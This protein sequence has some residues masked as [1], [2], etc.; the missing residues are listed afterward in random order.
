MTRWKIE[1]LDE[2][3]EQELA[4][5]PEDTRACFVHISELLQRYGFLNVGLPHVDRIRGNL[6]EM[7]MRSQ[8]GIA[9]AFYF[10]ARTRR[11]VVL[12][13]F[14]KRTM[15]RPALE[16]TRA[17]E[18]AGQITSE[19]STIR[20]KTVKD[21]HAEW[22]EKPGY[23]MAYAERKPEFKCA[24]AIIHA[25]TQARLTQSQL[26]ERMNTTRRTIARLEGGRVMPSRRM[27]KRIGAATGLLVQ[28]DIKAAKNNR[29]SLWDVPS[30]AQ[31][32]E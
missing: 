9:S 6:W 10:P 15:K 22:L 1:P 4:A 19:P 20:R 13:A 24:S 28:I 29:R 8:G 18:R 21:L 14:V 25:R 27:L 31:F 12:G 26:A 32:S 30:R 3:A 2:T 23:A 7:R 16:I 5:L 11:L 17:L